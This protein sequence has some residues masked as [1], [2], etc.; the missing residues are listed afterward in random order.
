MGRWGGRGGGGVGCVQRKGGRE[1]S[2][3]CVIIYFQTKPYLI[4]QITDILSKHASD[5]RLEMPLIHILL[6]R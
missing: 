3:T 5:H 6:P 4:L 1:R 2:R